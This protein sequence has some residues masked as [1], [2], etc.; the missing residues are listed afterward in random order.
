MFFIKFGTLFVLNLFTNLLCMNPKYALQPLPT[1]KFEERDYQIAI[2]KSV[3]QF[4]MDDT[5][6]AIL[7]ESATGS[8][9]TCM[10]LNIASTLYGLGIIETVNWIAMRRELLSQAQK[11]MRMFFPHLESV[12][13]FYSLFDSKMED[14]DLMVLDENRH[15][16]CTTGV[17][18][19]GNVRWKYKLGLDA[20]PY[21]TD[22]LKM[23]YQKKITNATARELMRQG[24][25]SQVHMYTIDR[26][27]PEEVATRYLAEPERWGKSVMFFNTYQQCLECEALLNAGG[28]STHVVTGKSDRETQID[29]FMNGPVQVLLNMFILTEGFDYPALQTAWVRDSEKGPVI[30]MAG[31]AFRTHPGKLF[32]NVVQSAKTAYSISRY[33][34]IERKYKWMTTSQSWLCNEDSYE[35]IV[36]ELTKMLELVAKSKMDFV[37]KEVKYNKDG[38]V[39]APKQNKIT[40]VNLN[41]KA[42]KAKYGI[43]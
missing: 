10:G 38:T 31:R 41:S 3:V 24:Y 32:C 18:V 27:T 33:C 16:A 23:Q 28:I 6:E 29:E 4:F 37:T 13:R 9:K 42:N 8:G 5:Y 25:L 30:Q 35:F 11:A 15:E 22:G 7:I 17:N 19:I 26:H 40:R 43:S 12:V 14:C 2:C 1:A 20:T 36:A 39:Q 21:R 34:K